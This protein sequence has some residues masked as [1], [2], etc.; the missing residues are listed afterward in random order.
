MSFIARLYCEG[1]NVMCMVTIGSRAS[2]ARGSK[3][4]SLVVLQTSLRAML[5]ARGG[6]PIARFVL[7]VAETTKLVVSAGSSLDCSSASHTIYNIWDEAWESSKMNGTRR[8][9]VPAYRQF[10]D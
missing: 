2:E 8:G 10:S 1:R 5:A 4:R 9:R 7:V 6:H 3:A